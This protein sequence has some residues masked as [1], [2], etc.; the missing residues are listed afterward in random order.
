MRARY[1]EWTVVA[2]AA[3]KRRDHLISLG[4]ATRRT[5]E[6]EEKAEASPDE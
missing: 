2:R 1:V 4:L 6:K 5:A 3:T